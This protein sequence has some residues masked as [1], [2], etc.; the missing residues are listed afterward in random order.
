[1]EN[2]ADKD[3][4]ISNLYC[5]YCGCLSKQKLRKWKDKPKGRNIPEDALKFGLI[6]SHP[7]KMGP[8]KVA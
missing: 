2:S 6:P 1:M 8:E 3:I 4:L 7:P 5:A